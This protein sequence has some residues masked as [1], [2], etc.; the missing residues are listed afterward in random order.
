[1]GF[2]LGSVGAHRPHSNGLLALVGDG[3]SD[4]IN[5]GPTCGVVLGDV[6]KDTVTPVHLI[7]VRIGAEIDE[8]LGVSVV[9]DVKVSDGSGT[10]GV[11]DSWT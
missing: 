3:V 1:M 6:R 10:S 5:G 2:V 4:G 9:G 7:Q 8:E 11:A